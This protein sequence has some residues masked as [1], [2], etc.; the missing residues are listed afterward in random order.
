MRKFI[1]AFLVLV[2]IIGVLNLCDLYSGYKLSL[3]V[4]RVFTTEENTAEASHKQNSENKDN[5]NNYLYRHMDE[6]DKKTYNTIYN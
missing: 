5:L 3:G 4:D 6:D 1:N 2:I